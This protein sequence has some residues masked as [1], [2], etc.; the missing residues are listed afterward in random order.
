MRPL[1]HIIWL[2]VVIRYSSCELWKTIECRH[3]SHSADLLPRCILTMQRVCARVMPEKKTII[4]WVKTNYGWLT[5]NKLATK[6]L[7]LWL[8]TNSSQ[9]RGQIMHEINVNELNLNCLL[10]VFIMM[11]LLLLVV[12]AIVQSCSVHYH[13]WITKLRCNWP[14]AVTQESIWK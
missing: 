11:L 2:E 3:V 5:D 14:V 12:Y 1:K 13:K 8:V 10:N 9:L 7:P 6:K 4:L